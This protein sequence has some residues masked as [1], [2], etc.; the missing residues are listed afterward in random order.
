[1]VI[2]KV[3]AKVIVDRTSIRV[4]SRHK[5]P[6]GIIG[7]K[8]QIEYADDAWNGLTKTAVFQGCVTK[9]VV[10][11]GSDVTIPVETVAHSGFMLF[12]GI[13]GVDV[14]NEIAVPT[15]WIPL[16]MVQ[17]AAD[18]SGDTSTDPT[19]P[20]W[21]QLEQKYEK[22]LYLADIRRS[23]F[24]SVTGMPPKRNPVMFSIVPT[25]QKPWKPTPL[26]TEI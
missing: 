3:I 22:L 23:R 24:P 14:E 5:I 2:A 26:L 11:I 19:L 1:M 8:V 9:D 4:V 18:P 25:G 6:K 21:A 13:Y 7:G 20:V 10:D 16:G 15:I 17:K 12:F